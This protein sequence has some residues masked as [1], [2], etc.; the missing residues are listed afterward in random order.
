MPCL[1]ERSLENSDHG[2]NTTWF[3]GHARAREPIAQRT[4]DDAEHRGNRDELGTDVDKAAG[5]AE[6]QQ[7]AQ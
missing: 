5:R 1:S 7:E 6:D 3:H 2:R 4:A